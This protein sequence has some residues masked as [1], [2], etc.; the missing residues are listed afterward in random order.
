MARGHQDSGV[1][2]DAART[3]RYKTPSGPPR[4]LL[5][6]G[7]HILVGGNDGDHQTGAAPER[8]RRVR[9]QF[10]WVDQRLVCDA[11]ALALYLLLVTPVV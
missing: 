8:L 9:T 10:G 6:F 1:P 3:L 7:Q 5:Q 11:T 4:G 2:I